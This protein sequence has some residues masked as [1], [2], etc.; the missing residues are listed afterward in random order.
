MLGAPEAS[1]F[2]YEEEYNDRE[3]PLDCDVWSLGCVLSEC[4]VWLAGGEGLRFEYE[5][6]RKAELSNVPGVKG[7]SYEACFHDK[8]ERL[9]CVTD[10]HNQATESLNRNDSFSP[11]VR[12]LIEDFMLQPNG[13]GR[14]DA[15]QVWHQFK[16]AV[17]NSKSRVNPN[18]ADLEV[19]S[20]S[21]SGATM[22]HMRT[23]SSARGTLSNDTSTSCFSG[24][25]PVESLSRG[26]VVASR[27]AETT[28]DAAYS[29]DLLYLAT[30]A[31]LPDANSLST[32]GSLR[33]P[34]RTKHGLSTPVSP[35]S[36]HTASN[37]SWRDMSSTGVGSWNPN[38]S[39]HSP[40]HEESTYDSLQMVRNSI[41][42]ISQD[43]SGEVQ[44]GM[45]QR[46]S[47]TNRPF[48]DPQP[49]L[50]DRLHFPTFDSSSR[51]NKSSSYG[52]PF[53]NGD[54]EKETQPND[55]RPRS[56]N[57][58]ER[59]TQAQ[60][61]S[62]GMSEEPY[63]H[64]STEKVLKWKYCNK[65]DRG[66]LEGLNDAMNALKDRDMVFVI[67]DSESMRK[68]HRY[69][70]IQTA[71]A[72]MYL[73]KSVDPDGIEMLFTSRPEGPPLKGRQRWIKPSIKPLI[74]KIKTHFDN[75]GAGTTNMEHA[76][77][78]ILKRPYR[79]PISFIVFTDG[80]WQRGATLPGGGV[81]NAI[82]SYVTRWQ[83]VKSRTDA[84]IMF[85][86]FGDDPLGMR[87]L[88]YLDDELKNHGDM[89]GR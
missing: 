9:R 36:Q 89:R 43:N 10:I 84:T 44:G 15:I 24:T 70:T 87:R 14:L 12:R 16:I 54:L 1:R 51:F 85:V 55:V 33:V 22:F 66:Q 20:P 72:L 28:R 57:R 48:S 6:R 38:N 86:R 40:Y 31:A 77:D 34:V 75:H 61:T 2:Y 53:T 32:K 69:E 50:D 62:A 8:R 82:I 41:G 4:F 45:P 19:Q 37:D 65:R 17:E 60:K 5:T 3:V 64:V 23:Q 21:D 49:R 7:S 79:R 47:K 76:L 80:V 35:R 39:P 58:A 78:I 68:N 13:R 81:E 25:N 27:A 83:R 26:E 88:A 52:P 63:P 56:E 42:P 30:N 18:V 71:E 59:R 46:P 67:D 74:N 11:V 73:V 29:T